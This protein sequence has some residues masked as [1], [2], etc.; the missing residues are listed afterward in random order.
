MLDNGIHVWMDLDMTTAKISLL[1]AVAVLSAC[2][3]GISQSPKSEAAKNEAILLKGEI[4]AGNIQTAFTSHILDDPH[5]RQEKQLPEE[6]Q[7]HP[8][9]LV[10]KDGSFVFDWTPGQHARYLMEELRQGIH[11]LQSVEKPRGFDVIALA[12]AREYWPKL[13][14]I[15]CQENP[16][17]RYY[18]LDG[19]EEYC[20][21]NSE[22][23]K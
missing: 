10:F 1:L 3:Y 13:R 23:Q 22:A 11:I 17:I 20:P 12:G 4:V 6:E 21:S 8:K 14:D 9:I 2:S 15:S 18:D 19:F 16:G 5:F 7:N